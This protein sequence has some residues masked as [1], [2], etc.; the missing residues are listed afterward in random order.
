MIKKLIPS[1]LDASAAELAAF[2]VHLR[3]SYRV[4]PDTPPDE[5]ELAFEELAD[6]IIAYLS[7]PDPKAPDPPYRVGACKACGAEDCYAIAEPWAAKLIYADGL[8]Y[9]SGGLCCAHRNGGCDWSIVGECA[10]PIVPV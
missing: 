8:G 5:A 9:I 7:S 10:H 4:P 6:K 1:L 3:G 2:R